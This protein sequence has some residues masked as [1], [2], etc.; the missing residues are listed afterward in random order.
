VAGRRAAT[1]KYVNVCSTRAAEN[2]S[3]FV[4]KCV[5][6]AVAVAKA[7]LEKLLLHTNVVVGGGEKWC[8]ALAAAYRTKRNFY[9]DLWSSRRRRRTPA[10]L[11][12]GG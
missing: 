1:K 12:V 8:T 9:I 7:N 4:R 5:F 3:E 6:S 10:L 2:E 11:P